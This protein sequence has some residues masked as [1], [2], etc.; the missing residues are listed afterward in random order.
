MREGFRVAKS[1]VWAIVGCSF[2][3]ST[4]GATIRLLESRLKN[5]AFFAAIFAGIAWTIVSY[6]VIPVIILEKIGPFKVIKRS[7]QWLQKTWGTFLIAN[8]NL[9]ILFLIP[10]LLILPPLFIGFYLPSTNAALL[11]LCLVTAFITYC[12][13]CFTATRPRE[14]LP[15]LQSCFIT[16]RIPDS[17]ANEKLTNLPRATDNVI[18]FISRM[19]QALLLFY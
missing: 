8:F 14:S 15:F 5:L 18:N 3:S 12:D 16:N 9:G 6:F 17:F 1:R 10:R 4:F 7:R 19:I 2:I 13:A 11:G